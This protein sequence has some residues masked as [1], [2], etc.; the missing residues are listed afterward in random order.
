[1]AETISKPAAKTGVAPAV[2]LGEDSENVV[3]AVTGAVYVGTDTAVAPADATTALGADWVNVGYISEDAVSESIETDTNDIVAWQNADVVRTL[4]TKFGV[5]Y[6]F[7]MIETKAA[8]VGLYYGKAVDAGDTTHDIGGERVGRQTFVID[9]I[10]S[11]GQ[12]MRR[13]IPL[14]E[15]TER[16]EVA[17]SGTDAVGYDCTL[18]TYPSPDID[19]AS[20]RVY[21]GTALA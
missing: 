10:D 21:Y 13:Y 5:S 20:V 12:V 9:A 6:Q 18:S 2:A 8:S 19:G 14:G 17:I 4:V 1:M 7:T 16:G 15:V 3:V 11:A